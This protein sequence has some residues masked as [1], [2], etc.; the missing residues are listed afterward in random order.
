[1]AET[2]QEPNYRA[3]HEAYLRVTRYWAPEMIDSPEHFE[4]LLEAMIS[5]A[6]APSPTP[7]TET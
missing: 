3:A 2:T 4:K 6:F 1:M 7:E 5:A